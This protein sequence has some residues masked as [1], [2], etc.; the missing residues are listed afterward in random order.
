MCPVKIDIADQIYKWR[1]VVTEKGLLKLS[2]KVGMSAMG[3]VLSHP[4]LFHPAESVAEETLP[5]VPR[6]LL[7][8][9][10]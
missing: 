7:Y 9:Q 2:K 8:N 5:H 3:A 1:R 4:R 10:R 6:F